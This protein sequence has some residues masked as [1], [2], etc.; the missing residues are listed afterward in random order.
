MTERRVL[1]QDENLIQGELKNLSNLVLT[2]IENVCEALRKLDTSLCEKIIADDQLINNKHRIIE[3]DCFTTIAT[4][5]P[6]AVDLRML[7]A[8]LH[9][10]IELERIGDHVAGMANTII[11]IAK[12]EPMD[13]VDDVLEMMGKSKEMLQQAIHAY[14]SDNPELALTIAEKDT[15]I[16]DM[17]TRLSG[18]TIA[19]ICETPNTAPFGTRLLWIIHNIERI[20][21]HTTNICEQIVYIH[22][23]EV[24]E[25]NR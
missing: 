14:M 23:G 22:Q 21:D 4:Q 5:Q 17:Q 9:L 10:S 3:Q 7:G 11:K 1:G 25:L 13:N 8:A 19:K 15:E 24:P 20:G 18:D 6:V 2:A 16:D 12:H